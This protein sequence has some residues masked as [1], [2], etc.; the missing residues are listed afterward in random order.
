MPLPSRPH[1]SFPFTRTATGV[2]S[3]EQDSEEHIMAQANMVAY[4]PLGYRED[5]PEFGWPWPDMVL[6][7]VPATPLLN[8]LNTFV[9]NGQFTLANAEQIAADTFEIDVN[10]GIKSGDA[11]GVSQ[12]VD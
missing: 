9:P 11:T 5:R 1:F 7:P 8:A 10:V 3:C 6:M 4:C 2:A 12:E